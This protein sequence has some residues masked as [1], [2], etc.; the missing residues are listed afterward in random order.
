MLEE[1]ALA[2]ADVGYLDH[3]A[4]M[5][6][7]I[8]IGEPALLAADLALVPD[9]VAERQRAVVQR[10]IVVVQYDMCCSPSWPESRNS[11]YIEGAS[12]RCWISSI[13]RSPEL[14]SAMLISTAKSTARVAEIVGLHRARYQPRPDAQDIDPVAMA[15]SMSRTT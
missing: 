4:G 11:L 7:R 10:L 1:L 5:G 12:L 6:L 8:E 15:A 2:A 3:G 13:C 14:A 9:F